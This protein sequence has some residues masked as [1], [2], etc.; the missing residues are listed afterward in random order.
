MALQH[1]LEGQQSPRD[2]FGVVQPVH[3]HQQLEVLVSLQ[4]MNLSG[5]PGLLRH[6]AERF[7]IDSHGEHAQ[8]DLPGGEMH[9]VDVHG[10]AQDL[11]E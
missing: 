11:S 6:R 5:D 1:P 7:G 10:E 3:P 8:P 2:A 4:R 9:P